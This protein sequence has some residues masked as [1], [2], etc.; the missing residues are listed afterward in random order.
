MLILYKHHWV[1]I[2]DANKVRVKWIIQ[3][4][5][6]QLKLHLALLIM[7]V[8]IGNGDFEQFFHCQTAFKYEPICF[9]KHTFKSET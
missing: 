6:D 3:Q 8:S 7:N 9:A 1:K 5:H 4:S 2:F